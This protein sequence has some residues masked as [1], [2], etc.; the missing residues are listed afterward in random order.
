MIC[1]YKV[2]SRIHRLLQCVPTDICD[3]IIGA[4]L[5]YY[6]KRMCTVLSIVTMH[7]L[8]GI[9]FNYL[10]YLQH[11][12]SLCQ[13]LQ[14]NCIF[15]MLFIPF[16][17]HFQWSNY[18]LHLQQHECLR[19]WTTRNVFVCDICAVCVKSDIQHVQWF[20]SKFQWCHL[21]VIDDSWFR[22]K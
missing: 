11:F 8:N 21:W 1:Y 17:V 7:T 22:C 5:T 13:R 18:V 2:V 19:V 20:Y 16:D 12:S 6:C 15:C 3:T 10:T 14:M 4:I 9:M